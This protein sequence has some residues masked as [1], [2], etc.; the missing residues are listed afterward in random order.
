MTRS[1]VQ[2]S[3]RV[4]ILHGTNQMLNWLNKNTNMKRN[5]AGAPPFSHMLSLD[6]L[7]EAGNC[8]SGWKKRQNLSSRK[9]FKTGL[10]ATAQALGDG[11]GGCTLAPNAPESHALG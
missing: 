8:G 5:A 9:L 6:E 4:V 7:R 3:Y 1:E 2:K 10:W 11:Q